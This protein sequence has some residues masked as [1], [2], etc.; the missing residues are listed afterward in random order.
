MAAA[1]DLSDVF[2]AVAEPRRRQII[3]VLG[4]GASHAVGE[5]VVSLGLPQP[6]VSKHLGVLRDAGIVSV[7][8]RGRHRL[9]RLEG[10]RL[11]PVHD[12]AK[13]F[14]RFWGHQLDRIKER[15]ERMA[16]S[17]TESKENGSC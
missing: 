3:G 16:A 4:D 9:Y 12:W 7:T 14:E 17:E 6:T 10:E 2:G 13:T 5:L 11:K 1:G 8:R 15:A